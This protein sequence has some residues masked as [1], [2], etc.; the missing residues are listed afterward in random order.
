MAPPATPRDPVCPL[1]SKP[2]KSGKLVMFQHG[3]LFHVGCMNKATQLRA[4]EQKARAEAAYAAATQNQERAAE[5]IKAA[6]RLRLKC[7]ACQKPLH[8]GP[9]YVRGRDGVPRHLQ[10]PEA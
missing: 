10:C 2:I 5:L 9:G 7:G 4:Y 6:Q 1:C 8:P 3:E